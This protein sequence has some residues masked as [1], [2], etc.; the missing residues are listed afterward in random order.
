MFFRVLTL[1]A[2]ICV[3]V[4][5]MHNNVDLMKRKKTIQN[6]STWFVTSIILID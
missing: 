1:T 2:V 5:S 6:M 3:S 4:F